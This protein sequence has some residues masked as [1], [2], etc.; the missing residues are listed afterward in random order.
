MSEVLTSFLKFVS[1]DVERNVNGIVLSFLLHSILSNPSFSKTGYV[2]L[3]NKD[4]NVNGLFEIGVFHIQICSKRHEN[5]EFSH[6]KLIIANNNSYENGKKRMVVL[7]AESVE[8]ELIEMD[9]SGMRENVIIDLNAEGRRW[10]GCELNGKP[11]GFGLEYSE[12]DNLIYEGFVFEG[13]KVCIG[14]EWNDDEN[15]NCLMYDGGYC[16]GE[17]CGKG[18][19]YDFNGN[20]DFEGEWMNNH[21]ITENDLKNDLIVLMF[22]EEFVIDDEMFNDVN[23]TTLHFSLLFDL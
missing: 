4:V 21:V 11:F 8:S 23:I 13:T 1:F 5:G 22:I 7:T 18:K 17:R 15:N 14:K 12:S 6:Y 20:A 16:N 2:G 10:E 3:K 9:C 19:S